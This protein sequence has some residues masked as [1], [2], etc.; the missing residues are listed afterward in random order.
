MSDRLIRESMHRSEKI[1]ELSDFQFRLW[2]NLITYV[3]DYGRGDA[4]SKIIKGTCFPLRERI[5]CADIDSALRKMADMGCICLYEVDGKPY[6]C[7]PNWEKHQK[8]RN[9]MSKYP[10]P[11]GCLQLSAID[12]NC[13]QMYILESE[14][15]SESN[16]NPKSEPRAQSKPSLDEVVTY[17]RERR[18]VVNPQRFYEWQNAHGWKGVTDWQAAIRSWEANGIDKPDLHGTE[19]SYDMAA[20]EEKARTTVPELKKRRQAG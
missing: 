18:S 10:A 7:F 2:V 4:R 17:C 16:P 1:S 12:S 8:I 13:S 19:A 14:S 3:D 9:K 5:S 6:L 15:E 20:A 11:D